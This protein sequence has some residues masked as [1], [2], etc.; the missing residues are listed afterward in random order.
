MTNDGPFEEMGNYHITGRQLNRLWRLCRLLNVAP[1][2][3]VLWPT[4]LDIAKEIG[5]GAGVYWT[6]KFMEMKE[7]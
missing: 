5:E 3:R 6:D 4:R 2:G 7:E 1:H